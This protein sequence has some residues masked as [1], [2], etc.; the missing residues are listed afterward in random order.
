MPP[1]KPGYSIEMKPDSLREY[2]FPGGTAWS[3]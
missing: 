1:T 3:S 2:A